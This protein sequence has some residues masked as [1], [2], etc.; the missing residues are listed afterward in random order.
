MIYLY[1]NFMK[2]LYNVFCNAERKI[3]TTVM[4]SV[5][6]YSCAFGVKM[7]DETRDSL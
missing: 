5:T 1:Y 3:T 2:V 6:S 4:L 7:N